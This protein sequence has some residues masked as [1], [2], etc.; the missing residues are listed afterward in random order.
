MRAGATV[1]G[2]CPKVGAHSTPQQL[3]EAGAT[4]VFDDMAD[5]PRLLGVI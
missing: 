5:L 4:Q 1:W 3:L 2:F